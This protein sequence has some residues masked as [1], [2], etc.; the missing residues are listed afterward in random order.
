VDV[1]ARAGAGTIVTHTAPLPTYPPTL[2]GGARPWQST[3]RAA[4]AQR[5]SHLTV[6]SL[7]EMCGLLH[8]ER[9]GDKVRLRPI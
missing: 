8:L 7:K 3:E 5:L 2:L 6:A 9:S 1:R 4:Q